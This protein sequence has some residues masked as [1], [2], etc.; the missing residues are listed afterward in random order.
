M[1]LNQPQ[2]LVFAEAVVELSKADPQFGGGGA[3]VAIVAL[4]RREDVAALQVFQRHRFSLVL[5]PR[6]GGGG[7]S[8]RGEPAGGGGGEGAFPSPPRLGLVEKTDG[9]E[10][11]TPF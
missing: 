6:G 2:P 4:Q 8:C 5:G 1:S 7:R 9:G 3:A 11:G 10:G